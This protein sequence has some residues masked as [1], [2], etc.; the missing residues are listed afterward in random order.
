MELKPEKEEAF[1][2]IERVM[3]GEEIYAGK[4][5]IR[6]ILKC[7]VLIGPGGAILSIRITPL[8]LIISDP[9]G[10]YAISFDGETLE[11]QALLVMVS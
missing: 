11:A 7:R 6:P 4:R 2:Q 5:C 10:S 8:A 3:K 1:R 9:T